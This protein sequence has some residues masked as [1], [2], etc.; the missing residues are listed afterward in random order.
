MVGFP[1]SCYFSGVQTFINSVCTCWVR[2]SSICFLLMLCLHDR[3]EDV[4]HENGD[5]ADYDNG[6]TDEDD[7]AAD[8]EDH[9][10]RN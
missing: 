2:Q 4:Q 5:D 7:T 6:E 3:D 10:P 9:L 8:D 1:L